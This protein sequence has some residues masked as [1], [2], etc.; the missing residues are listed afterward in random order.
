GLFY[1][2]R[3]GPQKAGGSV[4]RLGVMEQD[5]VSRTGPLQGRLGPGGGPGEYR[6]EKPDFPTN[7]GKIE[8]SQGPMELRGLDPRGRAETDI[9]FPQQ[10]VERLGR[11]GNPIEQGLTSLEKIPIS[12]VEGVIADAVGGRFYFPQEGWVLF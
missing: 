9:V 1:I 3:K 6:I 12:V 11:G 8:F 7:E 5:D 4:F 10:P 2:N